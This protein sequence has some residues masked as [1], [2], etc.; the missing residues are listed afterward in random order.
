[1]GAIVLG[2][3]LIHHGCPGF[4]EGAQTGHFKEEVVAE[5]Q[6]E[7]Q[8]GACVVDGEALVQHAL[9]EDATLLKRFAGRVNGEW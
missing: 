8:A 2:F 6:A 1:M 5:V 3:E 7:L 4:A 9:Q